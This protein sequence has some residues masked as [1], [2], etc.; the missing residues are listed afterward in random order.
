M[1]DMKHAESQIDERQEI[2]DL[3]DCLSERRLEPAEWFVDFIIAER[4]GSAMGTAGN[5]PPTKRNANKQG[6]TA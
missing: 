1:S 2:K 6:G 5:V 4:G 3:I